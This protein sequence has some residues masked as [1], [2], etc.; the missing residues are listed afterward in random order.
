MALSSSAAFSFATAAGAWVMRYL[1]KRENRTIAWSNVEGILRYAYSTGFLGMAPEKTI[2]KEK[3]KAGW[4][5]KEIEKER[6][7]RRS[8]KP[9]CERSQGNFGGSFVKKAPGHTTQALWTS[10]APAAA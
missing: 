7:G 8:V 9:V 2:T 4:C 3:S 6:G 5:G 10:G 1:L